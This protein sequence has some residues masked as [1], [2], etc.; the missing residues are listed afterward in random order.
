[1]KLKIAAKFEVFRPS[2]A[3]QTDP[4][5]IWNLNVD[6]GCKSREPSLPVI[7][8]GG[9]YRTYG[10]FQIPQLIY[11][12]TLTFRI[13]PLH[14]NLMYYSLTQVGIYLY[15]PHYDRRHRLL[16]DSVLSQRTV[17]YH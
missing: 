10:N 6:H 2:K 15:S 8:E 11:G 7:G 9:R 14:I 13:L 3:T 5:E 16:G 17:P 4:G 1:M 12:Y